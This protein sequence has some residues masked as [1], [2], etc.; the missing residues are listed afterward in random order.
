VAVKKPKVA[1]KPS[2]DIGDILKFVQNQAIGPKAEGLFQEAANIPM[3]SVGDMVS[4]KGQQLQGINPTTLALGAKAGKAVEGLA[5]TGIGQWFGA[6]SA[7]NL[8][9]P[10]QSNTDSLK[11]IANMLFA[12]APLGTGKVLKKV[13]GGAVGTKGA[14]NAV[15]DFASII[16]LLM[17]RQD[18]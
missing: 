13:K 5:N 18:K 7:F 11:N 2:F 16:K 14:T 8:G 17:G 12:V 9:K 3:P 1:K 15:N 4:G 10:N 6:D